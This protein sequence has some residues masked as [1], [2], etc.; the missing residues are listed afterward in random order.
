EQSDTQCEALFARTSEAVLWITSSETI[1]ALDSQLARKSESRL[2]TLKET[3]TVLTTHPRI[4]AKCRELG[5]AH[6]VQIATGIQSVNSWLKSNKKSM[7]NN[8]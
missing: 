4:T 1:E 6:V 2:K 5:Y 8:N 7:E 3:A